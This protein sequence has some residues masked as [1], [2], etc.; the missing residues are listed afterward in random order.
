MAQKELTIIVDEDSETFDT[1]IVAELRRVLAETIKQHV[2][3]DMAHALTT[4]LSYY[5][6]VPLPNE[7]ALTPV[8]DLDVRGRLYP[9]K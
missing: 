9:P 5:G 7:K 6:F 8:A 3:N 2:D 4:V 1:L